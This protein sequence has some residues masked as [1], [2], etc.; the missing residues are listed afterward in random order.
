[1]FFTIFTINLS[2]C[3]SKIVHILR[4]GEPLFILISARHRLLQLLAKNLFALVLFSIV[5]IAF[6]KND[7]FFYVFVSRYL[8]AFST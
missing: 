4:Q 7:Y 1:M 2:A 8:E 3:T 6:D 5:R